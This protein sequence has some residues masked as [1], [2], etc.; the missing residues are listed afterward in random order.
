MTSNELEPF[1]TLKKVEPTKLTIKRKNAIK[2]YFETHA[3]RPLV[4]SFQNLSKIPIVEPHRTY[5]ISIEDIVGEYTEN[6]KV[7]ARERA[8][9]RREEKRNAR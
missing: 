5:N 1:P 3:A 9:Q 7:A 6:Q 8:R 2:W 4:G